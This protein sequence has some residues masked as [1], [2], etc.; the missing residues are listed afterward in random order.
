MGSIASYSFET[1]L[2]IQL[3]VYTPNKGKSKKKTKSKAK[4]TKEATFTLSSNNHLEFLECLLTKH[5]WN[6]TYKVTEQKR[7]SFKYLYSVS[8]AYVTIGWFWLRS[9]CLSFLFSERDAIDVEN[10]NDYC[11]MVA[12]LGNAEPDKIK[13]LVDMKVIRRSCGRVVSLLKRHFWKL[14]DLYKQQNANDDEDNSLANDNEG[15]VQ[16]QIS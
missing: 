12:N 14:F 13:I 8:K 10:V 6:T 5:R 7:F 15:K 11:E 4:K 1:K 2:V 3:T 9:H 16:Y